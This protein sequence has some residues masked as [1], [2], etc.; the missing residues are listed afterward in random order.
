ML[1]AAV[2]EFI[3]TGEPV[4]SRTLAKKHGFELSAATIRNVLADLEELGYLA[5]PHTS[6][7]RIPTE[8]AFR[9]FID[10][11]MRVRQLTA[12][13]NTQIGELFLKPAPGDGL[14]RQASRL[15]SDMTGAAA[16]LVRTRLEERT[17]TKVRFIGLGPRV[18]AVIV[19]S[20]GTVENRYIETDSPPTDKELEHLHNMLEEVVQG[21][22]LEG[23]HRHF[24]GRIAEQ[25]DELR[26]YIELGHSLLGATID[27][28]GSRLDILIEGKAQLLGR[29]EFA[30]GA[31]LRELFDALDQG[32]QLVTLLQRMMETQQVQVA[33]GDETSEIG[34]VSLVAAP[35]QE[36]NRTSGALGVIGPTRMDYSAVVPLVGATANAMSAALTRARDSQP[37]D[38][39]DKHD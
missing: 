10:A 15:L 2:R 20:D 23:L 1:Y 24:E 4:G 26:G 36:G 28:A 13:E 22:T 18:L 39:N 12:E 3:E 32:E 9:L 29:P 38:K 11:L 14:F 27:G 5:Q 30:D 6:A 16:V 33:L 31:H 35:Y 17:L 37:D 34:S 19:M 25:R 8:V 7:G 21:R